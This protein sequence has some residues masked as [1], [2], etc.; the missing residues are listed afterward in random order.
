MAK[1]VSYRIVRYFLDRIQR[2][3]QS[4]E[5]NVPDSLIILKNI[6]IILV[7]ILSIDKEIGGLIAVADTVKKSS[8]EA[9]SALNDLG[10][11]ATML[12]GDDEKTAIGCAETTDW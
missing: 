5:P 1:E 12:T 8:P 9:I 6:S 2:V 10:I 4:K 11:E 3:S 7:M